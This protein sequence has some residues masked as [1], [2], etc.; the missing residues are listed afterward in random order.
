MSRDDF[1][2]TTIQLLARR[3]GY[4]CSNPACRKPTSGP[5]AERGAVN[6]G[7]AAHITA[8][9]AG[10][11]RFNKNMSPEERSGFDNGIWLCQ[12]CSRLVDADDSGH[13]VGQLQEWKAFAEAAAFV[14][15]RGFEVV[16]G[17]SFARLEQKLPELISEMRTDLT[18]QPLTREFVVLSRRVLYNSGAKPHFTYYFE[19]HA[20]L[21][22]KLQICENFGAMYDV[23]FNDVPRFNFTEEFVDYILGE[24]V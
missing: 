10:G 7:V 18:K 24:I 4:K 20:E 13:S 19:D 5:G 11:V 9:A 3:V 2:P 12:Q 8:A 14:E 6:L 17:R 22:S 1:S 16:Q 15:L 21:L 23:A